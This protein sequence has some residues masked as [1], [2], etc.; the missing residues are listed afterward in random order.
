MCASLLVPKSTTQTE[1]SGASL[2]PYGRERSAGDG[3]RSTFRD[4]MLSRPIMLPP[5]TVKKIFSS[6]A[7]K[8]SVWGSRAAGSGIGISSILPFVRS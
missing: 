8:I 3:I 1:P 2:I 7:S 5:W 4:A 6:A